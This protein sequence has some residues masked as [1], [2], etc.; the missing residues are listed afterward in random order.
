MNS[1]R[2]SL[3]RPATLGAVPAAADAPI[4]VVTGLPRSGTSMLMQMLVAG[5]CQALLDQQRPAD[6]SNPYG[7][8]EY[9]PVTRLFAES[10]WLSE[11]RGR[12]LKVVAPLL[13]FLPLVC[14][15]RRPLTYRVIFLRRDLG[16]V[17]A[18]Q[19]CLLRCLGREHAAAPAALLI[20][21]LQQE[22][23][24]AERWIG[25]HAETRLDLDFLAVLTAPRT[26]AQRLS[27]F[28]PGLDPERAAAAVVP[29]AAAGLSG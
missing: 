24:V 13:R 20:P 1:P 21:A 28:L 16:Q 2:E 18:S 8:Y 12:V 11:A 3:H 5:G 23:N 10:G 29:A 9:A 7:Y 17:V 14:R 15:E 4:T 22:L 26:A 6:A 27:A 25:A 19:R